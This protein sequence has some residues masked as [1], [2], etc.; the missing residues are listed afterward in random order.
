[1]KKSL[2]LASLKKCP[3]S[4]LLGILGQLEMIAQSPRYDPT[5]TIKLKEMLAFVND[6]ENLKR[7]SKV[8]L[9]RNWMTE[10]LA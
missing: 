10:F 8:A 3:D 1:M 7:A 5:S 2:S 4:Q 6:E 9:M